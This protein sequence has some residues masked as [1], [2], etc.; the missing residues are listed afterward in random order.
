MSV[1]T[2]PEH[3]C[4]RCASPLEDGDLRCA[5]CARPVPVTRASV[6]K[7]RVVV[8]RCSW[9]G[10]S[11]GFDANHQAPRCGFC[12]SV[13]TVE[14]P[15]D[16]IETATLRV[17]F[18]VDRELASAALRTWLGKRG[19]FAPK[20]LRDEAVL[21]SLTPL[22]WAAWIVNAEATVAWTADSDAGSE[23]SAWAPHAGQTRMT[24]ADIAVPAS[25]GLGHDECG[26]L[27]PYYDLAQ[28]VDVTDA[29]G[30]GDATTVMIESF[31]AQRS[32]AR[33]QVHRAIE[34][35]AKTRVQESEV[36]GR[37]F[38]N[39]RVACLLERLTTARVALPAW[40]LAYR[41]RGSAYRAIVHGQRPEIVFGSS[42]IDWYK[43]M[44]LG[45]CVLVG[46]LAIVAAIVLLGGRG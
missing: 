32:A 25:R 36:P 29:A 22:C 41:Y 30:P 28:V 10:A 18:A 20:P 35:L 4:G 42:P 27:V 19:F 24:F 16:P 23:R 13:M 3:G 8:L 11:V 45:A 33:Q 1:V 2:V 7:P 9:C 26:L 40:V 43:V 21:E 38:R 14:Q 5:V 6:E 12:S 46:V 44:R 17:P 15:L 37:R 31:D 34:A 39:V